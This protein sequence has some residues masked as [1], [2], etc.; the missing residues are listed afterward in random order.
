MFIVISRQTSKLSSRTI[1]SSV[2][3]IKREPCSQITSYSRSQAAKKLSHSTA[4]QYFFVTFKFIALSSIALPLHI[5]LLR[6]VTSNNCV[7]IFHQDFFSYCTTRK[8]WKFSN[9]AKLIFQQKPHGRDS[10]LSFREKGFKQKKV[11]SFNQKSSRHDIKQSSSN[12][13]RQTWP[14][15]YCVIFSFATGFA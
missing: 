1:S 7:N 2:A 11:L 3:L 4:L 5:V 15:Q 9:F 14:K 6:K 10:L 13:V 12:A 8:P